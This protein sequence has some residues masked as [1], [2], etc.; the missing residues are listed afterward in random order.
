MVP[1]ELRRQGRPHVGGVAESMD[2]PD[3]RPLTGSA[4]MN[5]RTVVSRDRLRTGVLLFPVLER[6]EKAQSQTAEAVELR[7][8]D[9]ARVP[10]LTSKQRALS[11]TGRSPRVGQSTS[12]MEGAND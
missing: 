4:D 9:P 10:L 1:G 7:I 8:A 12:H 6:S 5:R 3:R 11:E 2:Q